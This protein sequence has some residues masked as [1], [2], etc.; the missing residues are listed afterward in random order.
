MSA[1]RAS[2]LNLFP[3]LDPAGGGIPVSALAALPVVATGAFDCVVF[4]TD[5]LGAVA[6]ARRTVIASNKRTLVRHVLRRRWEADTALV[7]HVGMLKLAPILRGFRGRV[8]MFCH[9]IE[10]WRRHGWLTRRLLRRVDLFL[11]NSDYTWRRFLEYA[12]FLHGRPHITT[13]LGFGEPLAGPI[14]TPDAIPSAVIVGRMAR[15]E[16]YKGHRELI[17]AWPRVLERVPT[18]RLDVLGDGDLRPELEEMVHQ[19]NLGDRIRFLGRVSEECK[20]ELLAASRCLAMPS[21]NEGFGIV[22][23]EAMRLGRPCLVSVCDAG[24][25][26]VNP[27]EA[28]LAVDARDLNAVADALAKLLSETAQWR[29]WSEAARRR[30]AANYTAASFQQRLRCAL[31]GLDSTRFNSAGNG[32]SADKWR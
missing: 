28:G 22:Y 31:D 7:W 21:R 14:P 18:A 27:P 2:A 10:L 29:A 24:R 9:G 26:V 32:S 4:G 30:Y 17:A 8:V 6:T 25:E 19:R 3:G 5:P 23:L 15:T 11:S 20:S 13:G 16:D 12:P 1:K